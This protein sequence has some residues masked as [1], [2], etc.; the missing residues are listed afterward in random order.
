ME[1]IKFDINSDGERNWLSITAKVSAD[2]IDRLTKKNRLFL[3]TDESGEDW[4]INV[5]FAILG[6]SRN[7]P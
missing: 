3:A 6:R 5:P 7:R 2:E 4:L 1:K